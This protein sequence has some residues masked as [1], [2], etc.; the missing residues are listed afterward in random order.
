MAVWSP[1]EMPSQRRPR[2]DLA[3]R[4]ARHPHVPQG[5]WACSE[6]RPDGG[7]SPPESPAVSPPA[8]C[9]QVVSAPAAS[10]QAGSP[11]GESPP[12]AS[13]QAGSPLGE[14]PPA[15]GA[16]AVC[17]SEGRGP[18]G[19]P[20]AGSPSAAFPQEESQPEGSPPAAVPRVVLRSRRAGPGR[21]PPA[22]S[23]LDRVGDPR[24]NFRPSLAAN[25]RFRDPT[26]P[27]L[28]SRGHRRQAQYSGSPGRATASR[29]TPT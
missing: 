7:A 15:A 25:G 17:P 21:I 8:G 24:T 28:E 23:A 5:C 27:I 10:P 12:A 29:Q 26:N 16:P 22:G 6:E 3:P 14:S 13:P 18:E 19:C 4:R 1:Q 20:P 2:P 11:L 9:T